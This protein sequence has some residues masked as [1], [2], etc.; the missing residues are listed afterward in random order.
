MHVASK[1][2][3]DLKDKPGFEGLNINTMDAQECVP[4]SLYMFLQLRFGGE[5]LLKGQT[6]EEEMGL[7]CNALSIAQDIVYG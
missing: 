1:I 6:L 5:R 4:E 2:R 7:S 3:A